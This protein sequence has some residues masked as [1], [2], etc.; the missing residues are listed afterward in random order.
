MNEYQDKLSNYILTKT[1]P[2]IYWKPAIEN[3]E[4]NKLFDESK[5]NNKITKDKYQANIELQY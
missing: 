2:E 3:S 5:I 4:T 1:K